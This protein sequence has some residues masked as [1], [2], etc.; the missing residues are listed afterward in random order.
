MEAIK[1]YKYTATGNDFII[2]DKKEDNRTFDQELIKSLCARKTGIGSDGLI[3]FSNH[4]KYQYKI[5]YYNSDGKE[6]NF[7]GNGCRASVHYYSQI[8][9][10]NNN[11][12]FQFLSKDLLCSGLIEEDL[13]GVSIDL[14]NFRK[15]KN[16]SNAPSTQIV[17]LYN[18]GVPHCL[19]RCNDFKNLKEYAQKIRFH[20]EFL[21]EGANV[22]FF[23]EKQDNSIECISYERGVE[24]FTLA[25]GSGA[26]AVAYHYWEKNK[27]NAVNLNM[28][29]GKLTA[30]K[31]D[32]KSFLLGEVDCVYQGSV[33]KHFFQKVLSK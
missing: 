12:I 26:M 15:V 14:L 32:S 22:T 3:L 33:N 20:P 8:L 23:K 17:G 18:T 31:K 24:D 28:P 1:F 27:E 25:C 13:F 4:S 21:S 7:C 10:N 2:I 16:I 19:I 29:G 30:L 9:N 6:A 5:N 11:N